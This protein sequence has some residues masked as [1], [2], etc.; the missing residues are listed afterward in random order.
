MGIE[1][2]AGSALGDQF[3]QLLRL[4]AHGMGQLQAIRLTAK[5]MGELAGDAPH[6]RELLADV[7]GEAN[8]A[9][10]VVDG[11]GHA[12][13][14]PPVGIG[15][16]LVTHGWVELVHRPLQADGTF[17]N[18]V[19]QFE[20]LVLILLGDADDEPQ[21]GGHHAIAG[22]GA[23]PDLVLLPGRQFCGGEFLQALHGLHMVR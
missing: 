23:H 6:L 2:G 8:R 21:V 7:D 5:A 17:L 1:G 10:A 12:L 11:P 15:R 3:F 20:A 9:G 14:N 19:E 16:E 4:H 13:A 18:Q 22:A